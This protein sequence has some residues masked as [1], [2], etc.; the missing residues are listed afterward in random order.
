MCMM[1]VLDVKV[2]WLSKL[3]G[4]ETYV[5]VSQYSC[6]FENPNP[7]HLDVDIHLQLVCDWYDYTT[8]CY[9]AFFNLYNAH[10]M[11]IYCFSCDHVIWLL[12]PHWMWWRLSNLSYSFLYN[13]SAATGR[14]QQ[15]KWRQSG[16]LHEQWVGY[17]LWWLLGKYWCYCGVSTAGISNSRFNYLFDCSIQICNTK[18]CVS[19]REGG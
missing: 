7:I 14:R 15:C 8:F 4:L 17:C 19:K 9:H 2:V 10:L 1:L 11:L 5:C 6:H 18:Y 13:W 12:I 3:L 16:D